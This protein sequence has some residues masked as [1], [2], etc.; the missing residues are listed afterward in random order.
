MQE[1]LSHS[2]AD[3][4]ALRRLLREALPTD[5]VSDAELDQVLDPTDYLGRAGEFIDSALADYTAERTR[6]T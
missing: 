5:E 1:A 4:A 2:A 3:G 6:W